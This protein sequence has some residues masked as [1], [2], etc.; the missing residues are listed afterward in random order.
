M[1]ET[2]VVRV[3]ETLVNAAEAD[4]AVAGRSTSGQLTHWARLGRAVEASGVPATAIRAVLDHQAALDDLAPE[5]QA[6]VA[7]LW[8]QQI[9]QRLRTLDLASVH[10]ARQTPYAELDDDGNVI[11]I[12]PATRASV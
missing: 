10:E 9:D 6:A 11:V 5:D 7:A 1:P 4:G 12:D 3:E 2:R 8:A